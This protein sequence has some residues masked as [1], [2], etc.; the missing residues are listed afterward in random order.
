[1]R[2]HATWFRG[3]VAA[4]ALALTAPACA[5]EPGVAI[6]TSTAKQIPAEGTCAA[7]AMLRVGPRQPPLD[8][9]SHS[10]HPD[11]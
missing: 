3:A 7:D 4:F 2:H 5:P 10:A 9:E 8:G 6:G 11:H 1:M